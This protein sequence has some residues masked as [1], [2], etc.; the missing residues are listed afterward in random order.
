M[1]VPWPQEASCQVSWQKRER[2]AKYTLDSLYSFKHHKNH[3]TVRKACRH[4]PVKRL[5]T[6]QPTFPLLTC[7]LKYFH[8][9]ARSHVSFFHIWLHGVFQ[10]L[11]NA[12]LSLQLQFNRI[13]FFFFLKW[14]MCTIAEN[15]VE[16][17]AN[18]YINGPLRLKSISKIADILT[19]GKEVHCMPA[20]WSELGFS[21]NV[22]FNLPLK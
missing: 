20:R 21:P 11:Y 17:T 12:H 19:I 2:E 4:I 3:S 13:L 8:P 9:E 15:C 7:H 18:L 22:T 6:W 5:L 10:L 14:K 1:C 16:W